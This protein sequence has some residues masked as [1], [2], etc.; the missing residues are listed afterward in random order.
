M[1]YLKPSYIPDKVP[2]SP[3][4]PNGPSSPHT[5]HSQMYACTSVNQDLMR[6]VAPMNDIE[7]SAKRQKL[8][9]DKSAALLDE[10]FIQARQDDCFV[11]NV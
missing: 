1:D 3:S 5:N 4:L 2:S 11:S 6:A 9:S 10:A 7:R 8:A